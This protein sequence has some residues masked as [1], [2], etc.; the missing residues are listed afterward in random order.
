MCVC[1]VCVYAAGRGGGV[2]GGGGRSKATLATAFKLIAENNPGYHPLSRGR[3]RSVFIS[4]HP[5]LRSKCMYLVGQRI[6]WLVSWL[7]GCAWIQF[8]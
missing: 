4:F 5:K 6:G 1:V 7:V 3:G 8:V 2:G